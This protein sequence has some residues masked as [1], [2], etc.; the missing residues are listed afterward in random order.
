MTAKKICF[1]LVTMFSLTVLLSSSVLARSLSLEATGGG[2]STQ[3]EFV[4]GQDVYI[5]I[6]LD[7]VSN[8]AGCAFTLIYPP[9]VLSPPS[10]NA[11]GSPVNA[12]DVTSSF[13]F[14]YSNTATHREN[15]QE[16]GKILFGAA[17]TDSSTGGAKYESG[18]IVLFTVKCKVR[19]DAPVG[20]FEVHLE[21]TELL[22]PDGGWY[23][24]T[25][26]NGEYDAGVDTAASVPSLY[27]AHPSGSVERDS[28][29][30]TDDFFTISVSF[31]A[32]LVLTVYEGGDA[33]TDND[34]LL[35]SV[36]TNTG[37]YVD[38]NATGTDPNNADSDGDGI[39]DGTELG[40]TLEDID[41]THTDTGIF[42]PDLDPSNTTDPL[43]PDTDRDG[44]RDGEEDANHNGRFD[45]GESDPNSLRLCL[46]GVYMLLL[47]DM[48]GSPPTAEITE[49]SDGAIYNSGDLITFTG[50]G[51]DEEDGDLTGT[52]LLWSS[53]RDGPLGSG[54]SVVLHNLSTGIHKITLTVHD[55][56]N[57]TGQKTITITV[58][59][60]NGFSK[61]YLDDIYG[62]TE[63]TPYFEPDVVFEDYL[64]SDLITEYTI[65]IEGDIQGGEYRISLYLGSH[66]TST[67]YADIVLNPG[68]DESILASTSFQVS[69]DFFQR[70]NA[71]VMGTDPTI[72]EGGL[73]AL[74]LT[75][76]TPDWLVFLVLGSDYLSYIEVPRIAD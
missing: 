62:L 17:E 56:S 3:T 69:S 73:L 18:K 51:Y 15:S 67:V 50:E 38:E 30:L 14:M 34:G 55:S 46:A 64:F 35:D 63:D 44:L 12:E 49:P 41:E 33:D 31:S 70:Y 25:N 21:Q 65:Y 36:E 29:V 42:Q 61:F 1:C 40:L 7:D 47:G 8:V 59:E 53:D 5:N 32:P 76:D 72:L 48:G 11:E 28:P 37:T 4:R 43:D 20:S 22:S 10:T 19:A 66:E 71:T 9:N 6:A 24:D 57:A 60:A 27:G 23:T 54:S 2:S 45:S 13:P 39:Q 16:S 52:S 75:S 74:R 68:T 26:D 58:S